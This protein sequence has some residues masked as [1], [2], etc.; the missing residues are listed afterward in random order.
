V[1]PLPAKKRVLLSGNRPG[2]GHEVGRKGQQEW[3]TRIR[4]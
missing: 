1:L 4:L 2:E 3:G